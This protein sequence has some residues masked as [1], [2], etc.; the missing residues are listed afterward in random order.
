[1]RDCYQGEFD[2]K[3]IYHALALTATHLHLMSRDQHLATVAADLLAT[4]AVVGDEPRQR[5]YGPSA[6]ATS[7]RRQRLR[8]R[9]DTDT[10]FYKKN[11]ET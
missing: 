2:V 8:R 6:A 5:N 4:G 1:M 10:D 9:C 11:I 3:E 7:F